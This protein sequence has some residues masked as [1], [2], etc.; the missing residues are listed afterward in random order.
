MPLIE[1]VPGFDPIIPHRRYDEYAPRFKNHFLLEKED[2]IV[3]A[4]WHT[5]GKSMLWGRGWHKGIGQLCEDIHQDGDI[6][7]LILGGAGYNYF[8]NFHPTHPDRGGMT[9]RERYDIEYY[10]G[11]RTIEALVGLE[12]TT[13]GVINGPGFHTEYSVFC[14]ITLIADHAK[15]NDPHFGVGGVPPGDGVQI[16]WREAMGQKRYNYACLT[17][18]VF[19]AQEAVDVGL[20]NEVVPAADIYERAKEIAREIA[21]K[22]RIGRGIT[23]QVLRAPMRRAIAWELRHGFG[24]EM[25][26]VIANDANHEPDASAWI[27]VCN[28]VGIKPEH[29]PGWNPLADKP[30]VSE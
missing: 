16:A 28:R 22:D 9:P 6:D 15:I 5:E 27:D 18:Q 2:G 30:M 7:V 21:S 3:T 11:T 12:Q 25:F 4:K 19:T 29:K 24:S 13:I 17:N 8:E 1:P 20:A 14:D 26:A 23:T 10:D